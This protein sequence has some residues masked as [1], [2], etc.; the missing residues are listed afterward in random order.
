MIKYTSF[1]VSTKIFFQA[2]A[3]SWLNCA[4]S[5][6]NLWA[7][8][9]QSALRSTQQTRWKL[10]DHYFY[11]YYYC[12]HE[13]E[14][15]SH[16]LTKTDVFLQYQFKAYR[17]FKRQKLWFIQREHTHTQNYFRCFTNA[18]TEKQK[19]HQ[20]FSTYLPRW[21][22]WFHL[23]QKSEQPLDQWAEQYTTKTITSCFC[24]LLINSQ[25]NEKNIKCEH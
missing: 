15:K 2:N 13:T 19:N 11:Y 17:T 7:Q 16:I 20:N 10:K 6:R 12:L 3:S 25:Q 18:L 21:K 22:G 1:W 9:I 24:I 5:A 8:P 4:K 14:K 23:I